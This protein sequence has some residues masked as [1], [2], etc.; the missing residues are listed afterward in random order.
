LDGATDTG[1]GRQRHSQY[2]RHPRTIPGHSHGYG[3]ELSADGG[4]SLCQYQSEEKPAHVHLALT[5]V[6]HLQVGAFYRAALQ[7]ESRD[8]GVPGRHYLRPRSGPAQPYSGLS[9]R[10]IP[11]PH[12]AFRVAAVNSVRY[13]GVLK[14]QNHTSAAR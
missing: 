4:S 1:F 10:A 7:V 3:V 11:H 2:V 6:N 8:N 13:A 12:H 9:L 14:A 5:A